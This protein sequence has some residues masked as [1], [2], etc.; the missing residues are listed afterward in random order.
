MGFY[1][2]CGCSQQQ[3]MALLYALGYQGK[4]SGVAF[5]SV[6]DAYR[7]FSLFTAKGQIDDNV[8]SLEQQRNEMQIFREAVEE[9][10]GGPDGG[11][12][13][14]GNTI[15]EKA[16]RLE[17]WRNRDES[18]PD[19]NRWLKIN[20]LEYFDEQKENDE[21]DQWVF[22]G[23]ALIDGQQRELFGMLR[24][25]SL[26]TTVHYSSDKQLNLK[27]SRNSAYSKS[28]HDRLRDEDALVWSYVQSAG[29]TDIWPDG[30]FDTLKEKIRERRSEVAVKHKESDHKKE[31]LLKLDLALS[32]L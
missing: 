2:I 8:T 26:D 7:T 24:N 12:A 3:V 20:G 5:G 27:Q 15:K 29:E 14:I 11:C 17:L 23:S 31:R 21:F 30:S 1:K 13:W 4:E 22:L 25:Y 32:E 9:I 19:Y 10:L 6:Y 18:D 16:K 28:E